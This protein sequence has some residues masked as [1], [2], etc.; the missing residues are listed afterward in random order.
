[1][2][3]ATLFCLCVQAEDIPLR[4]AHRCLQHFRHYEQTHEIPT[5]LLRAVAV[6]ETGRWNDAIN[7]MIPWPWSINVAGK[8]YIYNSKREAIAAVRQFQ[9]QGIRSIDVGCMQINLHHHPKAFTSLEHAF[10]P[11]KNIDYAANFL[12]QKFSHHRSWHRAVAA[13]H[14]E[15][16]SLGRPYALKVLANWR[17]QGKLTTRMHRLAKTSPLPAAMGRAVANHDERMAMRR[18]SNII[19]HGTNLSS[20]QASEAPST[21]PTDPHLAKITQQTLERFAGN[22]R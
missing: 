4:D 14:S 20:A 6:T 13:Y 12:S 16:Q 11:E 3:G 9:S 19:V 2:M 22:E 15:T 10:E 21:S 1:M 8:P 17:E 7:A 5:N 18:R